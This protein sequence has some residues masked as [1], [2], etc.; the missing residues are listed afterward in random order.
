MQTAKLE[1]RERE[2]SQS[3]LQHA[4][5]AAMLDL[6]KD[7]PGSPGSKAENGKGQSPFKVLKT[8]D[9]SATMMEVKINK[10]TASSGSFAVSQAAR[11]VRRPKP[12]NITNRQ[13]KGKTN[14]NAGN[15]ALVANSPFGV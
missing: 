14:P 8:T 3:K 6:D 1:D 5:T 12:L 11:A 10:D 4:M 15:N 9:N 2:F 13:A 7:T